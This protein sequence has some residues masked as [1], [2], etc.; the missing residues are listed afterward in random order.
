M[1]VQDPRDDHQQKEASHSHWRVVE[2]LHSDRIGHRQAEEH[3][4]GA[5]PDHAHPADRQT[6]P[7]WPQRHRS[8]F[9][10]A[11]RNSDSEEYGQGV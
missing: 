1:S 11:M 7:A 10:G 8:R 9:K 2:R 6:Q 5:H 3:S 4:D